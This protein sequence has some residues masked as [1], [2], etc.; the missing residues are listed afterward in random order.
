MEL[1]DFLVSFFNFLALKGS[2]MI[3]LDRKEIESNKIQSIC[4]DNEQKNS[5]SRK[6]MIKKIY[7]IN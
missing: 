3:F 4:I 5:Y 1:K 2:L 7:K 6:A